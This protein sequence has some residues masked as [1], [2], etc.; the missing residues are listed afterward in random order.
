VRDRVLLLAY[1]V[2]S[3]CLRISRCV[4]HLG[5]RFTR[6]DEQQTVP[7]LANIYGKDIYGNESKL[8]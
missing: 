3:K 7:D 1:A 2:N 8:W 6:Q 5:F 4:G